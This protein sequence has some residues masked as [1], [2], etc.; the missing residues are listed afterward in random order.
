MPSGRRKREA[1]AIYFA[2]AVMSFTRPA[3]ERVRLMPIFRSRKPG[4]VPA[5]P[6]QPDVSRADC[7]NGCAGSA[8]RGSSADVL[9]WETEP[10]EKDVRIAGDVMA[11]FFPPPPVRMRIGL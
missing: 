5:A 4:A 1:D 7:R 10:L 11:H 2:L 6:H 8:V 3:A 9:T